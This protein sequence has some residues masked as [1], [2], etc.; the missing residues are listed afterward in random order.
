MGQKLSVMHRMLHPLLQ[1]IRF[2]LQPLSLSTVAI[3]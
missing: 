3:F 1:D 2:I